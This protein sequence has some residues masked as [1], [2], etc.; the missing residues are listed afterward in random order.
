LIAVEEPKHAADKQQDNLIERPGAQ[1]Q[2]PPRRPSEAALGFDYPE[3]RSSLPGA[4]F[5]GMPE[6]TARDSL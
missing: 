6:Q 5:Q 3:R 2:G 1:E 4:L